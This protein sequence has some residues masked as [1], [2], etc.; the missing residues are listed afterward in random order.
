MGR[1]DEENELDLRDISYG[2]LANLT[3]KFSFKKRL[4]LVSIILRMA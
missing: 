4:I 3:S 2:Y 1:G